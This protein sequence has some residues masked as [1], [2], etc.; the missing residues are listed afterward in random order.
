MKFSITGAEI[1]T[2][3]LICIIIIN[4]NKTY[5]NIERQRGAGGR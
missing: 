3:C 2:L 5:I 4:T 1:L